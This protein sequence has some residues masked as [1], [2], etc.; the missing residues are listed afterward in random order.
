[1]EDR[2]TIIVLGDIGFSSIRASVD[3]VGEVLD[4]I[5]DLETSRSLCWPANGIRV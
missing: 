4:W 5:S 3:E 2:K 1:V